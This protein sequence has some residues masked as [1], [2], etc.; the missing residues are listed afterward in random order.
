MMTPVPQNLADAALAGTKIIRVQKRGGA[1]DAIDDPFGT[2]LDV[3][4][5]DA[6]MMQA[7]QDDAMAMLG[8][9]SGDTGLDNETPGIDMMNEDP[10]NKSSFI[11]N[12]YPISAQRNNTA[13]DPVGGGFDPSMLAAL[14]GGGGGAPS[15]PMA[16]P[17]ADP[18]RRGAMRGLG[19]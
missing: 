5:L 4:A 7:A 15:A 19:L 17:M 2:T 1:P 9:E 16:D 12:D 18:R 14:M 11:E 3:G 8:D 13:P 6:P 10:V